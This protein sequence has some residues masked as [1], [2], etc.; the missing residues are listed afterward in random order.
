M[1]FLGIT[2]SGM[3]QAAFQVFA[4]VLGT[5][6]FSLLYGVPR[7]YYPYCGAIGGA[8]W[9]VY[10]AVSP[11]GGILAS[12]VATIAVALLS[13]FTAIRKRCPVTVFLITGIF[14]L[15][16]GAQVYWMAYYFVTNETGLAASHGY[17][18]VK[19]AFA[20]VLGIVFVFEIPQRVFAR[21]RKKEC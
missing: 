9:L 2:Q 12:L 21:R 18:A 11:W 10:L 16:P 4:A 6:A 3:L 15:V 20:I 7:K 1:R 17:L 13:R 8:G 5:M 19:T 14:P